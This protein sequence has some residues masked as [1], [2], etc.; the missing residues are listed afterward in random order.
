MD[1]NIKKKIGGFLG[2]GLPI[3][4]LIGLLAQA[5]CL[6]NTEASL[7]N[8]IITGGL[9]GSGSAFYLQYLKLILINGGIKFECGMFAV[10]T[11]IFIGFWGVGLWAIASPDTFQGI[12]GAKTK[13]SN[14]TMITFL[15][16]GYLTNLGVEVF[17]SYPKKNNYKSNT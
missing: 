13:V 5:V 9:I 17:H 14:A 16:C 8:Y 4:F 2:Y 10:L 1:S 7:T 3:I 12:T 15:V 6:K 11:I